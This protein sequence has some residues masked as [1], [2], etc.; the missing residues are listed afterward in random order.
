[1]TRAGGSLIVVAWIVIGL[2]TTLAQQRGGG[3]EPLPAAAALLTIGKPAGPQGDTWDSIRQLP[4]FSTTKW[5]SPQGGG[6][7]PGRGCTLPPGVVDNPY[8]CMRVPWTPA[9]QQR[10]DA[11]KRIA[12]SG[13]DVPSRS[14]QCIPSYSGGLGSGVGGGLFEILLTPGQV[15]ITTENGAIRRI[16][17]DGRRHPPANELDD[18]IHGHN[19]GHW[20]NGTLVVDTSGLDPGNE[21]TYGIP[22]GR[23]MHVVTRTRLLDR[24]T[25]EHIAVLEAPEALAEPRVTRATFARET[26]WEM[27]E[28]LC[29]EN[30]QHFVG[31]DG[32]QIFDLTPPDKR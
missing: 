13:G 31:A 30:N 12:E 5:T 23:G 7:G 28:Q 17:T 27:H 4:D 14:K 32:K 8:T 22:G 19:V 16:Y 20:E 18:S 26:R 24:N 1:M 21:I 25:M 6:P 29:V 15:T 11:V 3:P 2:R 9:W 10:F